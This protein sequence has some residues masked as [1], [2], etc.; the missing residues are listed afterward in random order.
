MIEQSKEGRR[1]ARRIGIRIRIRIRGRGRKEKIESTLTSDVAFLL[2][3][4][5]RSLTLILACKCSTLV[6]HQ[7]P[8]SGLPKV[9]PRGQ[10]FRSPG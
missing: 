1:R 7:L 8:S 2:N 4:I 10:N 3:S 6:Q 5:L 9:K